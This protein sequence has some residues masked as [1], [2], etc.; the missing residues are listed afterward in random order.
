[1]AGDLCELILKVG[2]RSS[3]RESRPG[4]ATKKDGTVIK[5]NYPSTFEKEIPEKS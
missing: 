5:S 4:T 3:V 2:H 1:M